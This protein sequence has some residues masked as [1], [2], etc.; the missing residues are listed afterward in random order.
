MLQDDQN[1]RFVM[2]PIPRLTVGSPSIPLIRGIAVCRALVAGSPRSF[3]SRRCALGK[4]PTRPGFSKALQTSPTMIART[5]PKAV[6]QP[7]ISGAFW[8][9]GP[10]GTTE[11]TEK[12]PVPASKRLREVQGTNHVQ[13]VSIQ[14]DGREGVVGTTRVIDDKSGLTETVAMGVP[15]DTG[16]GRGLL[17]PVE[18]SRP[19]MTGEQ[20]IQFSALYRIASSRRIG[21]AVTRVAGGFSG[22]GKLQWHTE[23][24]V[25]AA[26]RSGRD[27][28]RMARFQR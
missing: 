9:G 3:F 20:I 17:L 16:G 12:R 21:I 22:S 8:I 10:A 23:V 2:G 19:E 25:A 18:R 7:C 4:R 6:V 11:D 15:M 24:A 5:S 13:D 14:I 27:R 1:Q 28:M 26:E